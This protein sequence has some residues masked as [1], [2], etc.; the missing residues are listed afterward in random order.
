[1]SDRIT[2]VVFEGLGERCRRSVEVSESC[3]DQA[4]VHSEDALVFET[5]C[6]L[7]QFEKGICGTLPF[8]AV[9]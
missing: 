4:F 1:M 2:F 5:R 9:V 8:V 7:F 3:F 6:V